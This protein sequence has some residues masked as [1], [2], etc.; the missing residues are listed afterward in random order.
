M[1]A[2]PQALSPPERTL[3]T[4]VDDYAVIAASLEQ[5]DA[6]GELFERHAAEMHRFLSRRVGELADDLLGDLFA[7][8][9]ERRAAYRAEL[10][11]ARPWLYGIAANLVWRHHRAEATRYR[12]LARV[13]LT[14][15]APDGSH[16]AVSS[17]DAAA[18]R[19]RLAQ[20]LAALSTT[21]RDVVLLLA[22]GQLDQAEAAAALGIPLGTVRSRLHRVR[23]QLRP[24]LDDLQGA[25]R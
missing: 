4:T 15:V 2:H 10:A 6:F 17:A 11:D 1:R 8:A 14:V 22:W 20:A 23:Q 3:P 7:I 19:P 18:V 12:A 13:P 21:D 9:F 25:L 24:V 5:P 16:E